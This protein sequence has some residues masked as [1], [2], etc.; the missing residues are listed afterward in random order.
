[1]QDVVGTISYESTFAE[2]VPSLGACGRCVHV[3]R[4]DEQ[5][6]ADGEHDDDQKQTHSTVTPAEGLWLHIPVT[7]FFMT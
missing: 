4:D 7:S 3:G 1:M 2:T 5:T 6:L